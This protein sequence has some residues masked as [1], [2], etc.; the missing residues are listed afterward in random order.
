MRS[1]HKK[2]LHFAPRR[3]L[4][5]EQCIRPPTK[6]DHRKIRPSPSRKRSLMQQRLSVCRRDNSLDFNTIRRIHLGFSALSA[7]FRANFHVQGSES[8]AN[9]HPLADSRNPICRRVAIC[10]CIASTNPRLPTA[11]PSVQLGSR[12]ICLDAIRSSRLDFRFRLNEW[13]SSVLNRQ[14]KRSRSSNR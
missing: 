4:Q 1:V 9:T 7:F 12:S 6:N 5:L 8:S 10:G 3:S 2:P 13:I 14:H 11:S